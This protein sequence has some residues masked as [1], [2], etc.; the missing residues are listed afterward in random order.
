LSV[1]FRGKKNYNTSGLELTIYMDMPFLIFF[2]EFMGLQKYSWYGKNKRLEQLEDHV[3]KTRKALFGFTSYKESDKVKRVKLHF[4]TIAAKYDL[5]NTVLSFGI[6]YI[7]KR[8]AVN[9]LGIKPGDK[10]L[11]VCG[12]TG[13]MAALSGL[14]TG[15]KGM[16]VAYD[17]NRKMI[18]CGQNKSL[19]NVTFVQGDAEV[20]SFDDNTFDAASI[21]FGIRNVTHLETG[22]KEIHRILKKGGKMCCLEFSKPENI[23]F[24]TLYDF[25]S[26]HVMPLIGQMVTGSKEAYIAFPESIRAFPMPGELKQILEEIGFS[27]VTVKKLSNGIAVIHT[28]TK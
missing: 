6:H 14:K 18:E 22:F 19:Y 3:S 4:D 12:G 16:S 25:Y 27:K 2:K 1:F 15:K 11:D 7:W 17:I 26:F 8:I 21:G 24:R 28:C 13:D 9:S 20:I 10:I 5:M 23:W